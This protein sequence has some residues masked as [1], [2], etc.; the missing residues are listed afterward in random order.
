MSASMLP[1]VLLLIFCFGIDA[2]RFTLQN[3]CSTT[4]WPG[5]L[6]GATS[7][8][9]MNGGFELQPGATID[10]DAP[11]GWSG[12][13]WAR[14]G[15]TFDQTGK[16]NCDTADCGGVLNCAGAGGN[17]PATL[18]EFTLDSPMDFYDVSLVDGYNLPISISP[19]GGSGDQC[20]NIGCVSDL[21]RSCP[22]GLQ[23]VING[24][25]VAC[26]SACMA[27]NTPE[28]CCTGAFSNPNT[29]KP[30][31]YS[32][33]FKAS[34]PTA[35]SYAYDDPTSTFTCAGADYLISFC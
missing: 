34:C 5:I 31:N 1:I 9:L 22:V 13:F 29:C 28:Y 15:C 30:T 14:Q 35:Y 26:K 27:F 6:A 11:K 10:V 24:N 19:R 16:G 3:K 33:L 7:T 8:L 32:R 18:A 4:I 25:V 2:A 20:K 21:N 23:V 17:P 12:R